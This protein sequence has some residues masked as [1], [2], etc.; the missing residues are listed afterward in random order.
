MQDFDL[1]RS[2]GLGELRQV[3]DDLH[4]RLSDFI[5]VGRRLCGSGGL[6]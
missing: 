1:A 3:V 4:L 5:L 6:G 2:G